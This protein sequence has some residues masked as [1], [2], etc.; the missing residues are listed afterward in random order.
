MKEENTVELPSFPYKP[1][2]SV[3]FEQLPQLHIDIPSSDPLLI[4]SFFH[5][6][7]RTGK[8]V[9]KMDLVDE[10]EHLVQAFEG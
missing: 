8:N 4:S 10:Y 3:H 9:S 7:I 5:P 1:D 2:S 6:V